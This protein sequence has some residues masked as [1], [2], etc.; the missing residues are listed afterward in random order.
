MGW[1]EVVVGASNELLIGVLVGRIGVVA[2]TSRWLVG[3]GSI[4]VG[5]VVVT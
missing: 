5:V 1:L 3:V 2:D 4:W